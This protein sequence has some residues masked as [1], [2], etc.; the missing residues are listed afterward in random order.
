MIKSVRGELSTYYS[1]SMVDHF[2]WNFTIYKCDRW[3]KSM[4]R[5]IYEMEK[6]YIQTYPEVFT[7]S[8][9]KKDVN[10]LILHFIGGREVVDFASLS[11]FG[12]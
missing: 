12:L 10:V 4:Y 11:N 3:L 7:L 6:M 2:L 8:F 1:K 9:A 5:T